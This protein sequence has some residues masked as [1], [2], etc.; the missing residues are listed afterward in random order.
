[1]TTE[2]IDPVANKAEHEHHRKGS[3]E[4]CVLMRTDRS[5]SRPR[6]EPYRLA[7]HAVGLAVDLAAERDKVRRVESFARGLA[8]APSD[9]HRIVGKRLLTALAGEGAA[10][11]PVCARCGEVIVRGDTMTSLDNP[12][13]WKHSPACPDEGADQPDQDLPGMWERADFE[14][15][16]P[17]EHRGP[18]WKR[19]E[20]SAREVE[21][22]DLVAALLASVEAAKVRREEAK[23]GDQ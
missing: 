16:A 14:G 11:G 13:G 18:D 1:M 21:K 19:P 10:E 23:R 15:G 22:V 17:D 8:S 4:T 12:T 7:E 3:H 2:P 9:S 5:D 20:E 6:C